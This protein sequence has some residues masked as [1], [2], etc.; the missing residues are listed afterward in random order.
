M[1]GIELALNMP[2]SLFTQS[3]WLDGF[4][5]QM[6]H[7][8]TDSSVQ[9]PTSAFVTRNNAPVFNNAVTQ[10]GLPG[11]SKQVSNLRL[12]YE[13][14]GVQLA[15]AAYKRSDFIGQILDY[16]SDSQFTFIKGETIVDLQA[17]Y[18]FQQGFLKGCTVLLQGHNMSN[19][20]FREYTT[21]A[22]QITN[23]VR[24]GRTYYAGLNVK[25]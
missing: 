21:D 11:L 12:Y 18:E 5:V 23:E 7:S 19:Q 13:K 6:S 10:I 22:N 8:Y 24:Y 16:R 1:H 3:P 2:F 14:H 20:P 25:F 17:A 9:L 4:G 15:A